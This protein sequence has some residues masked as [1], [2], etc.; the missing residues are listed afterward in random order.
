MRFST[1]YQ[2]LFNRSLLKTVAVRVFS[3]VCVSLFAVALAGAPLAAAGA[4]VGTPAAVSAPA[5]HAPSS[6]HGWA[7]LLG[8]LAVFGSIANLKDPGSLSKKFVTR[9]S[10]AAPDYQ[11]GVANAGGTWESHAGASE[12]SYD[13]GVTQAIAAKRYGKGVQGKGGKFQQNASTLGAQRYPQGVQNAGD[14]WARGV[15]PA[16]A[17]LKSLTLPPKGPRRSPQNQQRSA[18]VQ[19]ALGAL[20]G[21]M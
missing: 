8:G 15:G 17:T 19:I 18:A 13:Q 16:F 1:G 4:I 20:K 7:W 14:A 12:S 10:A 3:T 9:A 11:A 5:S 6:S 21:G 2:Q